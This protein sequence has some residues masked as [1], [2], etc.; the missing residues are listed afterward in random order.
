M[1][2]GL[3]EILE[4][5]D[6]WFCSTCYTC[7][8]RCPR[9][10]PITDII[11]KIRNIAVREGHIHPSHRT[12]SHTVYNTGHGVPIDNERWSKARESYGLEPLHDTTH[13]NPEALK[14][15]QILLRSV[16][17]DKLVGIEPVKAL[18]EEKGISVIKTKGEILASTSEDED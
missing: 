14:E 2:L 11:L 1:Q 16:G 4:D 9:K 7:L 3:D 8:E 17:F 13:E 12:L 6:I 5:D 18:E 10:V 15:V